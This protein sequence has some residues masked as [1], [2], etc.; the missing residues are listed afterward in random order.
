M[1]STFRNRLIS[2]QV[3]AVNSGAI[4]RVDLAQAVR[5]DIERYEEQL[6]AWV[7]LQTLEEPEATESTSAS[8][9]TEPQPLA[10]IS[11]GV[12][13]I[14]DVAGLP[15]RSGS[16]I[17]SAEPVLEDASCVARFKEL[18]AVVQGKTVTTE[19]GYFSP[20]PTRNPWEHNHSPGG[21]SSGSAAAVGANTIQ[22]ALG[23]QTAGSLTRPAS[24]CGAAGMV[25]APG[26]TPMQGIHGLSKTLDSLGILTRTTDDL[27]T[28]YSAFVGIAPSPEP[29]VE[30]A[31]I[32]LWDGSDILPLA[33]QMQGLL[34]ELPRLCEQLELG[35]APL[36]WSD[37]V[38]TLTE[39]HRTVMGYEAAH[40]MASTMTEHKDELSPQLQE[41]LTNGAAISSQD[42][43]EALIR[44][45][46][47]RESLKRLLGETGIII[48][49]AAAGP[50]PEFST[51]TGSPDLSRAWQLLGLPTVTV[52]GAKTTSGLPLGIQLISLPGSEKRLLNLARR[53]E[54]LLRRVHSLSETLESP[55]LKDLTW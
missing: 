38:L 48:G 11:I 17:T 2:E 45:K 15:T 47:S 33:P 18:G 14:I 31:D 26:S 10:G 4:S 42:Y 29:E 37:H 41:L 39:D 22:I 6:Q 12:K 1:T 52:P 19:F 43:E 28:V 40:T 21:S 7:M 49:P 8:A 27:D 55:T 36:N 20:G 16:A 24:F 3:Q 13:D 44:R 25:L 54:A 5:T 32:F 23:T 50:A 9:S 53:L 34:T 46:C 51:G 30:P 35:T